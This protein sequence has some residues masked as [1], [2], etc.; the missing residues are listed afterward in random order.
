MGHSEDELWQA[1]INC[2]ERLDGEFFYGVK[3]VGV[4]CRPS[5]K[6]RTPLRKNVHYF[7]TRPEAEKAGF[8]PCK[9]CRPD[10]FDYDPML[11]IASQTKALIDDY[12]R[13]R[14][15]LK[16]EMKHLGV[17]ANHL[18]VIFKRHYGVPPKD[19]LNQKRIESAKKLLAETALPIIEI[20]EDIGFDSLSAFYG[21][22][23]RQTGT[24][25][26]SYR[27]EHRTAKKATEEHVS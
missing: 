9:R 25:P 16:E 26:N 4:Y 17:S 6:S 7:K 2:D 18:S 11:K 22:F 8:R 24:T 5:C 20:A 1:V 19:Y 12:Y 10:L 21:F 3:T 13:E 23:R 15:R 27:R 14:E